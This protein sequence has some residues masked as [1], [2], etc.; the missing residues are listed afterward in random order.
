MQIIV[1]GSKN[2]KYCKV[3]KSF[4]KE[5]FNDNDWLYVDVFNDIN[6]IDLAISINVDK[7]PS[8]VVLNDNNEILLKREGTVSADNIFKVLSNKNSIP[9]DNKKQ[10][11]IML[12]YDPCL[13]PGQIVKACK[14]NGN[15]LFNVK[16]KSCLKYNIC[17]VILK[18]TANHKKKYLDKGG[19]KDIFWLVE[20]EEEK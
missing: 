15:F 14:H 17:S 5:V 18:I 2:C 12:S 16:I 4:M 9:L 10:N 19:R 20:F 11:K 13:I 7:L 1:F 8:V 6:G 3:Q